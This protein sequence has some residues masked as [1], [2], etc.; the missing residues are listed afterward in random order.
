MSKMIAIAHVSQV[1]EHTI[2]ILKD[3]SCACVMDF[4]GSWRIT[5]PSRVNNSYQFS[6]GM[7]PFETLYGQ[8]CRSAICWAEVGKTTI[9]EP[10]LVQTRSP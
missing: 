8:V 3:M 1:S 10:D 7:P 2:Q 6:I 4:Q 5:F 9:L